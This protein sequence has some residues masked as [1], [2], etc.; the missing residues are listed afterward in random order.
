VEPVD[1][2]WGS[3]EDLEGHLRAEDRLACALQA[4]AQRDDGRIVRARPRERVG[5]N[6]GVDVQP[7]RRAAAGFGGLVAEE[8]NELHPA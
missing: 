1:V 3:L 7:E 6:V 2:L 4:H 8:T 5:M